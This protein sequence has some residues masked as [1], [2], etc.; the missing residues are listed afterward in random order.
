MV[1][2]NTEKNMTHKQWRMLEILDHYGGT[3]TIEVEIQWGDYEFGSTPADE[4]KGMMVCRLVVN[5]LVRSLVRKGYATDDADGYGITEAGRALLQ[6]R[7]S[8]K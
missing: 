7:A 8:A 1:N 6:R 5:S 3:G 4:V 2:T